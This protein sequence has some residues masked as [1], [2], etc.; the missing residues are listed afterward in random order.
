MEFSRYNID[1]FYNHIPVTKANRT[2]LCFQGFEGK[3]RMESI[4]EDIP[5]SPSGELR[6]LVDDRLNDDDVFETTA[7]GPDEQ[8]KSLSQ[9]S[10]L[11]RYYENYN[12]GNKFVDYLKNGILPPP[13]TM[14]LIWCQSL[15]FYQHCKGRRGGVLELT[16]NCVLHEIFVLSDVL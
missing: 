13:V 4:Q 5:L 14:L 2:I 8:K 16:E 12:L 10:P 9:S 1:K 15:T 6:A 7:D 3:H 11:I